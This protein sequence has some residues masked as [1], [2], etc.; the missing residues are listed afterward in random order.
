MC[1]PSLPSSLIPIFALSEK[2]IFIDCYKNQL[3][4]LFEKKN[5]GAG[6]LKNLKLF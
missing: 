5:C 2:G 6:T 3:S 1:D 4:P